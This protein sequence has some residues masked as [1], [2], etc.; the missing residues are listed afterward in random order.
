MFFVAF[1]QCFP[2]KRKKECLIA[3]YSQPLINPLCPGGTPGIC[4]W[5][6]GPKYVVFPYPVSTL[7]AEDYRVEKTWR[8]KRSL[9]CQ[10]SISVEQ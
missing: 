6:R 1:C 8:V 3:G 10:T 5:G 2:P 4:V 9:S 7:Q